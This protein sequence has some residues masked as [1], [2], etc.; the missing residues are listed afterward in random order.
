MIRPFRRFLAAIVCLVVEIAPANPPEI[1]PGEKAAGEMAMAAKAFLGSLDD[2]QRAR[3][4]IAFDAEERE[5]WNFVPKQ[6]AGIPWG[7]L[8][9]HQ[10][11]LAMAL[12]SNGLS[13]RGML[14]A[15]TIMSLE[16]VL[17]ELE[18]APER[19]DPG[20]YH[21]S[22][23]G[24]PGPQK[25]WGWRMEGHHLSINFTLLPG[26]RISATP[27]FFGSNPAEV[28]EGPR[29]GLRPLA[30][31]EDKA[32]ALATIL[33]EAGQTGV[34]F[35]D[36]APREILTGADRRVKQLEPVGLEATALTKA[37]RTVLRELIG[38]YIGRHREEVAA[39]DWKKIED[40]GFGKIRFGWAGETAP[41]KAY[42]YRVQGP[43][44]LLE[45][46]NSQNNANHIHSVW[47]DFEGDFGRDALGDH[48]RH[49]HEH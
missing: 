35:S 19:R 4:S 34:I 11:P 18:Q 46:A 26:G 20:K 16:H 14:K 21:F 12:L 49:G 13:Q 45:C 30:G 39:A 42:Y 2:T 5:N 37:Q 3:A 6:R 38:E 43:T 41:G 9:P 23:F 36:K 40:A 44:F 27:S 24:E 22:V 17:A 31:E 1:S 47:R 32:R 33:L 10:T 29:K 28:R 8:R 25:P 48:Y 15:T 7:E